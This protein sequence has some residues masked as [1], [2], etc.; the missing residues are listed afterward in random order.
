M[1]AIPAM[2]VTAEPSIWRV[3][4]GTGL[5]GGYTCDGCDGRAQHLEG[6]SGDRFG[7]RLHAFHDILE[8]LVCHG[9]LPCVPLNDPEHKQ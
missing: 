3:R 9:R 8:L 2:G 1:A 4:V 5:D 6:E 7:R